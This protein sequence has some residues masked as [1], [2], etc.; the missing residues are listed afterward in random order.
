MTKEEIVSGLKL[1]PCYGTLL[2]FPDR[3]PWGDS[4]YRGN[5][6]GWIHAFLLNQY[7]V[8]RLAELFAGSGTGSDVCRDFGIPY[9]GADLNPSPK[10]SDILVVDAINDPVPDAFYGADM[11]FMHPPY[12]QVIN[13]P[14]AGYMYKDP[15]HSLAKSDL[16]QMPWKEFMNTLNKI[17]MK[18][19]A[20]IP[21]NGRMSILMGDVKKK[22]VLYSMISDI[23]KPGTLEQILIKG[24]FNCVSSGRSYSGN[25]F[26][27]ITHEYLMVVRKDDGY[28]IGFSLPM[29]YGVDIRNSTSA[30]WKDIVYAV[31]Q[32]IGGEGALETIYNEV[33]S[34]QRAKTYTSDLKAKIRQ[35]LQRSPK[36]FQHIQK[37]RWAIAS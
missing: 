24:Q 7:K 28:W 2:N 21:R 6:S 17:V 36:V 3:G 29:Q 16:G 12:S 25:T 20:S 5:C 26:V 35:T 31:L 14:Y 11:L 13:I 37:G 4:R 22:G 18:Y 9:V 34:Y 19:Y 8:K 15:D 10:R 27:P 32:K 23:V 30:T 1:K 33:A